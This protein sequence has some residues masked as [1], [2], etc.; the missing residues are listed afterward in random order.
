[1]Y[2]KEKYAYDSD[3]QIKNILEDFGGLFE[4]TA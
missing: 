3:W 1:M 4:G 2:N